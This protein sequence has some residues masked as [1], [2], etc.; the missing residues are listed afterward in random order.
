MQLTNDIYYH[1]MSG[2]RNNYI[3]FDAVGQDIFIYDRMLLA[4]IYL[5]MIGCCWPGYIYI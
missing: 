1:E 2:P 3:P 5:Y 4:R